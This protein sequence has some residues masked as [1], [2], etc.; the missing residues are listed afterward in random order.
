LTDQKAHAQASFLHRRTFLRLL[1]SLGIAGAAARALAGDLPVDV[2][3]APRRGYWDDQFDAMGSRRSAS[4]QTH[5]PVFGPEAI[6]KLEDAIRLYEAIAARDGWPTV[7]TTRSLRLGEKGAEVQALR[8]RLAISGDLQDSAGRSATFDSNVEEAVKRF[9]LRHGL[10]AD[11]V[12]GALGLKALN[13]SAATRLYQLRTNLDRLRSMDN[14]VA[15]RYVMVNIPAAHIEAVENGRVVYR[16]KAVVGRIDRPT[17]ILE[18]KIHEVI[19]NPYWTAPRSIIQKDIMPL[20]RKNPR[21]LTDNKIRLFDAAGSEVD[22][23]S[24]DWNADKSPNLMFRQD[25]G[26]INAMASTK[27]NFENDHAV[28]MHDTP[29]QGLFNKLSRFDSSGCVRVQNIRDLETWL[30]RDTPRWGRR[31]IEE[32]IRSGVNT[33]ISLAVAIPVYF[34]Y[35]TAWS[36]RDGV[37]QF[38]D[39]IYT[40]DGAPELGSGLVNRDS[41]NKWRR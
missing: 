22:P 10:P 2:L 30:L 40:L 16:F 21:Y 37:V 38:R 17:P 9:Q 8:A 18:S 34:R 25:P 1:G 3:N 28:Y 31:H 26:R 32:V 29:Q 11:G 24:V 33:P 13:I 39:D 7:G 14:P 20:M 4:V 41:S 6:I 12:V 15:D 19:L 27:I 5:A 23:A 35:V 36:A